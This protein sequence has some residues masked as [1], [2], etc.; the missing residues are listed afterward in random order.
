MRQH[1][2]ANCY[3]DE[4]NRGTNEAA[5]LCLSVILITVRVASLYT[6]TVVT[7]GGQTG[8]AIAARTRGTVIV[9]RWLGPLHF[10]GD[11]SVVSVALG[12]C[13]YAICEH[14]VRCCLCRVKKL[15]DIAVLKRQQ[16]ILSERVSD[17]LTHSATHSV[18]QSNPRKTAKES[19][20]ELIKGIGHK[21]DSRS[22]NAECKYNNYND[23]K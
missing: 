20:D 9:W 12:C 22:S 14:S 19:M 10:T 6:T 5:Q 13:V 16:I 23:R 11:A 17:S 1:T 3:S 2:K 15:K 7:N 8:V 21:N 18:S 4:R